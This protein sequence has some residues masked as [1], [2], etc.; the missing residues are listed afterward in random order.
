[1]KID[2]GPITIDTLTSEEISMIREVAERSLKMLATDGEVMA[3]AFLRTG[4]DWVITRMPFRNTLEKHIFFD[5]FSL[6]VKALRPPFSA[7]ITKVWIAPET[8]Q[9]RTE[10]ARSYKEACG[11]DHLEDHPQKQEMI[12]L[13][14]SL[15]GTRGLMAL[16]PVVREER[17][18]PTFALSAIECF[19]ENPVGGIP[20]M[21]AWS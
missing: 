10:R 21:L 9:K 12:C 2:P 14:V 18:P 3:R 8:D 1:M 20:D 7:F 4:T 17:R 16:A 13:C 11:V 5:S 15:H 6:I 19:Y